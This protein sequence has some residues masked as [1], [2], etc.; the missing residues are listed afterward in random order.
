MDISRLTRQSHRKP[1]PGLSLLGQFPL[2][3]ARAHE[4]CGRARRRL[5][6]WAARQTSGPVLWIRPAWAPDRLHMAGI[7]AEIDP[8]RLLIAEVKRAEDLLWSLEEALRSGA[9]ALAVA[10]L[11]EP[12]SLTPVRRLHLAAEQGAEIGRVAPLGLLLTPGEG[13]A[14]GVESRWQLEPRHGVSQTSW[15]LQRRRARDAPEAEWPVLWQKG[16]PM[17][18]PAA[19]PREPASLT[20]A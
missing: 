14:R 16:A 8:A 6:L 2:A 17:L 10:E 1:A 15:Q 20:P 13:G 9:V 11:P 7:R 12:P 3:G 4:F 18:V 5:A 19:G